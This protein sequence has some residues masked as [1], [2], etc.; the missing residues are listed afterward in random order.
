MGEGN[1]V[2]VATGELV[3]VLSPK[4]VGFQRVKDIVDKRGTIPNQQ[5]VP[6][7]RTISQTSVID[8][9]ENVGRGITASRIQWRDEGV[10]ISRLRQ[11][12]ISDDVLGINGLRLG[13]NDSGSER[14]SRNQQCF[15]SHFRIYVV[16]CVYRVCNQYPRG[17]APR[18]RF[19]PF[20]ENIFEHFPK[21]FNAMLKPL[22]MKWSRHFMNIHHRSSRVFLWLFYHK[23]PILDRR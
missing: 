8:I 5:N 18:Q 20:F 23:T 19:F 21:V 16:F 1:A 17:P 7:Q 22:I 4:P 9:L 11:I 2:P 14:R 13:G 3:S 10:N 12:D 15:C 6:V